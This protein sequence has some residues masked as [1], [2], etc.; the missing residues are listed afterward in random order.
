MVHKQLIPQ[1]RM[2]LEEQA[3]SHVAGRGA[4]DSVCHLL[5]VCFFN[6]VLRKT[7]RSQQPCSRGALVASALPQLKGMGVSSL[8]WT[9]SAA[10]TARKHLRVAPSPPRHC[11]PHRLGCRAAGQQRV[12]CRLARRAAAGAWAQPWWQR[13]PGR[14]RRRRVDCSG[15]VQA[16]ALLDGTVRGKL[17][18]AFGRTPGS[19][20]VT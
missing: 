2:A 11:R 9:H 6:L 14:E 3:S 7:G 17:F 8:I 15:N 5:R 1:L 10:Q 18:N 16:R 13:Q 20:E 12:E 4:W 19:F